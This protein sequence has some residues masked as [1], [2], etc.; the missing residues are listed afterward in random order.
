[1]AR[2]APANEGRRFQAMLILKINLYYVPF[3]RKTVI[4][5]SRYKTVIL[6]S[7]WSALSDYCRRRFGP[8]TE[9]PLIGWTS[10]HSLQIDL[11]TSCNY[12]DAKVWDWS[13][14]FAFFLIPRSEGLPCNK[15]VT[16]D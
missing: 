7:H 5:G 12:P 11:V 13:D 15:G 14:T 8:P 16:C 4:L 9:N 1:M 10:R 2:P 6:G 3:C